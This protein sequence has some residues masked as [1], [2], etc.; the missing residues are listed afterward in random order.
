M[1]LADGLLLPLCA[2]RLLFILFVLLSVCWTA[3]AQPDS[4][5]MTDSL[6][7]VP[8]DTFAAPQ[9]SIKPIVEKIRPTV[10]DKKSNGTQFFI[11]L[12]TFLLFGLLRFFNTK[13]IDD[14]FGTLSK[15]ALWRLSANE[16]LWQYPSR[17]F[18]FL[19]IYVLSCGF[20]VGQVIDFYTSQIGQLSL[21]F[22]GSV[23]VLG[24]YVFKY[25][26]MQSVA[27]V[28]RFSKVAHA[29]FRHLSVVNQLLGLVLL[30]VC[31]ILL[32]LPSKMRGIFIIIAVIFIA[33]VLI[34]K[35]LINVAYVR[36]IPKVNYMHFIVYLC[37]LELIPLAVLARYVYGGV[38]V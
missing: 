7:E 20:I 5:A 3:N 35:F 23:V 6:S 24:I 10:I 16:R 36:N 9:K 21:W 11:G 14:L 13:Y 22:Y 17:Q 37:T 30:P 28:F 26:V 12:G 4:S 15:S 38:G 8:A 31:G 2:V 32:L 27:V 29:F 1:N 18:L 34:F 19:A 33:I 25:L